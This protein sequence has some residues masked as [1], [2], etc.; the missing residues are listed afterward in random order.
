MGIRFRS[1]TLA[2]V[3]CLLGS[4]SLAAQDLPV[5]PGDWVLAGEYG[6]RIGN[7]AVSP[8]GS[9]Q[10]IVSMSEGG[11]DWPS[12]TV[13]HSSRDRGLAWE[14]L[15]PSGSDLP[16]PGVAVALGA[17]R[18]EY[19]LTGRILRRRE[20]PGQPWLAHLMWLE[21]GLADT[22]D[23]HLVNGA[24]PGDLLWTFTR[25]PHPTTRRL[26]FYDPVNAS[27]GWSHAPAEA[28]SGHFRT[29]A[30]DANDGLSVLVA[31]SSHPDDHPN[32]TWSVWKATNRA[33]QWT[34]VGTQGLPSG[35]IVRLAVRGS[36]HFAVMGGVG[37]GIHH[38]ADAS[39]AWLSVTDETFASIEVFDL[40]LGSEGGHLVAAT[41]EGVAES[42]DGGSHW[43]IGAGG[44]SG[45]VARRVR[46][47]GE[48]NVFV[49]LDEAG[50]LMRA[51]GSQEF[52]LRSHG[53]N[54]LPAVAMA[55]HP[56]DRET[57]SVLQASRWEPSD[58]RLSE[59]TT[60][61]VEWSADSS[62]SDVHLFQTMAYGGD[63]SFWTVTVDEPLGPSTLR[64]RLPQGDWQ[65]FIPEIEIDGGWKVR[66]RH[67]SQ[68]LA[69]AEDPN[70]LFLLADDSTFHAQAY[71]QRLWRSEDGGVT[72]STPF[73]NPGVGI[74]G[75][76]FRLIA[77]HDPEGS[78]Y[79]LFH[80]RPGDR[81]GLARSDDE[82]RTWASADVSAFH[83]GSGQIMAC[84]AGARTG[85]PIAYAL[86]RTVAPNRLAVLS[87]DDFGITWQRRDWNS[88]LLDGL[89][90]AFGCDDADPETLWLASHSGAIQRS[91]N[92]GDSF[93]PVRTA[94]PGLAP[95]LAII[96][97]G[98]SPWIATS[99]GTYVWIPAVAPQISLASNQMRMR[100]TVTVSWT[101]GAGPMTV[102]RN[103]VAIH[104]GEGD[105]SFTEALGLADRPATYRVC[106]EGAGPCST[107]VS[108]P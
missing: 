24:S 106:P 22:V 53:L 49:A 58:R 88:G 108:L 42:H 104:S 31:I 32:Q 86:E 30:V 75:D 47:D 67:V 36:A 94:H 28:A 18:R 15:M 57:V 60:A 80:S 13:V 43:T 71:D 33:Q 66:P 52:T 14:P 77:L 19:M 98:G 81:I 7:L 3:L 12:D 96:S 2:G 79:L 10:V 37:G 99:Q 85:Q 25:S 26:H 45:L 97:H 8:T 23:P 103:G 55:G 46:V 54:P 27:S 78:A 100:V 61:G 64:R 38:R 41:S 20:G 65:T 6:G 102:F 44:T 84:V 73:A 82:G 107:E 70:L 34:E 101:G 62:W 90:T 95:A 50:L 83:D 63:G 16:N 40:A 92:G 93:E 17:D 1:L 59:T 29:L 39:S 56:T 51:A 89:P 76:R 5:V 72:W 105:G 74:G 21:A 87:S 68:A 48:G 91:T 4:Y 11:G 9:G 35:S 69:A